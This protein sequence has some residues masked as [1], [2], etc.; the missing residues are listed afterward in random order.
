MELGWSASGDLDLIVSRYS[1]CW[2]G[3]GTVWGFVLLLVSPLWVSIQN[4]Q[5]SSGP[6][7]ML[8]T[9]TAPVYKLIPKKK[10]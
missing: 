9:S 4:S 5:P 2:D 1:P 10:K 8:C 7:F 3:K 6:G